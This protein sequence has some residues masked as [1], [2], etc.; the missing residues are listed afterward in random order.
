MKKI[1]AVAVSVLLFSV[2]LA[3]PTYAA[4]QADNAGSITLQA[5]PEPPVNPFE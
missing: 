4:T 1:I 5:K 3:Y 2:F